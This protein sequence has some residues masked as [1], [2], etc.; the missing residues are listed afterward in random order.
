M[1]WLTKRH[2][3]SSDALIEAAQATFTRRASHPWPPV[4]AEPPAAWARQYASL[5]KEMALEPVTARAA[6]AVLVAFLEPVLTGRRGQQW[7]PSTG[8]WRS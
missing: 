8:S 1:V 4:S 7:D 6:H 3:F 5:R 2:A